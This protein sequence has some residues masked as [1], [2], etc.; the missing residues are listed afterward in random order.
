MEDFRTKRGQRGGVLLRR[1]IPVVLSAFPVPNAALNVNTSTGVCASNL[2]NVNIDTSSN[3]VKQQHDNPTCLLLNT[4]YVRN[5]STLLC[6]YVSETNVD[7]AFLTE[8]W[9]KPSD[10]AVVNDLVPPGYGYIGVC[11]SNKRG[12][13]VGILHKKSYTL[14]KAPVKRFATF[15]H[16]D[17]TLTQTSQSLRA[18]VIYRP[19]TSS[20]RSFFDELSAYV[21]DVAVT[22]C[23]IL[24]AGDFNIH[25]E[26]NNAPGVER[27]QHILDENG[28]QQHVTCPTHTK[29]HTLDLVITRV[30]EQ[31]V[32]DIIVERSDISDHYSITFKLQQPITCNE[33][34]TK[35]IRDCRCFDHAAYA[36]DL[37]TKLSKVQINS[38]INVI[39]DQYEAAAK[40]AL[41]I[42]AP[43]VRRR[44]VARKYH[45][46]YNDDIHHAR[47]L[48]RVNEKM[49]RKTAL[50]IHRQIFA[51]HRNTVNAMIHLAKCDYFKSKLSDGD[52]KTCFRVMDSLFKSADRKLPSTSNM[53]TLCSDF[54]GFFSGKVD[55]IRKEIDLQVADGNLVTIDSCA[56][57]SEQLVSLDDTTEEELESIIKQCNSKTCCLDSTPTGLLKSH[58]AV[59]LPCLVSL[60]NA[61]LQQGSF[62]RALKTANVIPVLK[63]ETLDVNVLSNYRPVSNISFISKL[64]EKVVV[65]R[66]TFHLNSNGLE[67]QLQSAYKAGHSTETTLLKVQHDIASALDVNCVVMLVMLDLSAAFDCV[68]QEQLMS[69]FQ[70]EY[71]ICA[72]ALSWFRS[73]LDGRTYRVQI[74]DSS[75]QYVSLWCGVA[76][77]S[78]LG[79]I[80][81]TMYTAPMSHIFKTHGVGYH[82]YADD[83]QIYV[84]FNPII[85][86]D[87]EQSITRLTAC[88]AE[89]RQWMLLHHLKLNDGKTEVIRFVSKHNANRLGDLVSCPVNIGNST[90]V[91][92]SRVRNLGVIM[93][94]HL[95][96]I[97]NV[98][99]VCAS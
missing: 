73:Y 57:R 91:P 84:S 98:S 32:S 44:K 67:D 75:S 95:S 76:Q 69:L 9:L 80:I 39:L 13:G 3:A 51:E 46:W 63:K 99:A 17:V 50:E 49:W 23:D 52:S 88:L 47:K 37:K 90:I 5:K 33:V 30:S 55:A 71:G 41:D 74:D 81:F 34:Q 24:I 36:A 83:I 4:R 89:L 10:S 77:G 94:Q 18:N 78:V 11:R 87:E 56:P 66:L 54:A 59:H 14:K 82:T 19:P 58:V 12:G 7:L 6:G 38:D 35:L 96:M 45:P 40:E 15:E 53:N 93:D 79:P 28:L 29:G 8:T 25:C 62:P 21:S 92:K 65:R 31:T 48:R 72:S 61:S 22:H 60:V 68:D 86:G 43:T 97:D 85:H 1:P 70:N 26:R 64:I 42:A 20:L 16:V 2:H 27:M